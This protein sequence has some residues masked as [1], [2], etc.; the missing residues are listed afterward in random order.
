M[1]RGKEILAW[2]CLASMMLSLLMPM[3][4]VGARSK[5]PKL[6]KKKVS[7]T[8][9][10]TK[11]I[12]VKN[13]KGYKFTWKS[14]KKK[15]VTVKKKGKY[16]ARL[17]AKKPGTT[18][19]IVKAKKGKKKYTMT[20]KVT[21]TTKGERTDTV[22]STN[23]A[24][25]TPDD[26]TVTAAPVPDS[27][28]AN[29]STATP[30][31][32]K[33]TPTATPTATST[34]TPTN[35]P[36][37]ETP[38]PSLEPTPE[39]KEIPA[40]IDS[41]IGDG[42]VI[43]KINHTVTASDISLFYVP[44]PTMVAAGETVK[45]RIKGND[46]GTKGFRLWLSATGADANVSEQLSSVD[47]KISGEFTWDL[48]LTAKEDAR[49]LEIK[50]ITYDT[51]IENLTI[52]SVTVIV[53]RE[54]EKEE[55]EKIEDLQVPLSSSMIMDTA[56]LNADPT[57]NADG[58]MTYTVRNEYGGG[59]VDI[60]LK[61]DKTAIDTTKYGKL[62]IEISA[63]KQ[64]PLAISYF[65]VGS[66]FWSSNGF[67]GN[68]NAEVE[69]RTISY[70]ITACPNMKAIQIR[71]RGWELEANATATITI[72]SITIVKDPRNITEATTKYTSMY[73]LSEKYGFKMGTVMNGT[74][75]CDDKYAS[76]MKYHFNSL[77][78]A[79]EMKAYSMLDENTS[80]NNYKNEGSMPAINFTNADKIMDYAKK[81][82]LQVRG[83]VLVWD[84]DMCD[85][86]FREGYDRSKGYAS[87]EVNK[88]RMKSYIEQVLKH[89]EQKY[90][91]VI[92]CWDV[93]NEAVGD[94]E[95]EYK[96]GDSR[97]VR[98][99]R[100]GKANLFYDHV[101]SDYVELAFL[102]ARQTLQAMGNPRIDLYYNDY[103]TFY[104]GKR[105]AICELIKS[106]NRYQS[107]GNGGYL[108][109]C[110]G[111]GM[112]SYIGGFG[113]QNGCMNNGDIALVKTAMLKFADLGIDVQVTE[114]AVRNYESDEDT[115]NKHA[116][117]YRNLFKAYMEV[118]EERS[119][120]PLKAVSI[121]GIVDNPTMSQED[122]G[123]RM[124]GTYCGLFDEN[125][126]VKPAFKSVYTLFGGK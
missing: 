30:T 27:P 61:T 105:D 108:K 106:I 84:A 64:A 102:Y 28:T 68:N 10:K 76:L 6:N 37:R 87:A 59:G 107:D 51:K 19:V 80:R 45:L 75:I 104:A 62:L 94:G 121:W 118:N 96:A 22:T 78:A 95:N 71:L 20:C 122:Y 97:H 60:Y 57:F 88:K 54:D 67:I 40:E 49:Y 3:G 120:K 17:T 56:C 8:V 92:Y 112:Q 69:K 11:I 55:E 79:N 23:M 110:D 33:V 66:G 14:K 18:K 13:A 41:A 25:R 34:A 50:G 86:F 15:V 114:L 32:T 113:T 70:S 119:N 82:G 31:P 123:Y 29:S 42:L 36:K 43:D 53:E 52:S 125:L 35:T 7:I 73:Q 12:K 99:L 116:A 21:V 81:N 26:L 1:K 63:E 100:G 109:L 4:S 103:S 115:F 24:T 39:M 47:H 111:M 91:G 74:T 77:T 98:T 48:S 9:G 58:S 124:N 83:H 44:L 65:D 90:P 117:F 93:V 89:F 38:T 126:R 5:I 85:W 16:G 46:R 2:A 101:G 72:H